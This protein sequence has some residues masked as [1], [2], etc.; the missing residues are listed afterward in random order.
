MNP[1]A[2]MMHAMRESAKT[3]QFEPVEDAPE[4][5]R[6]RVRIGANRG[7]YTRF[8]LASLQDRYGTII[9]AKSESITGGP[10]YVVRFHDGPFPR[11]AFPVRD[12]A[13]LAIRPKSNGGTTA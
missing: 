12:I 5:L 2:S 6:V 11:Y 13:V 9:G 7:R 10:V 3:G 4:Y 1:T 8:A